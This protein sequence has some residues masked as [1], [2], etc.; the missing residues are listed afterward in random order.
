MD[1]STLVATNTIATLNL[2]HNNGLR[3]DLSTN[4]KEVNPPNI[5][6]QHIMIARIKFI[7]H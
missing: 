2:C 1:G 4:K 7:L 5:N 6:V 3:P